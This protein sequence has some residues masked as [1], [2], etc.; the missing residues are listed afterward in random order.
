[1]ISKYNEISSKYNSESRKSG[2]GVKHSNTFLQK[3]VTES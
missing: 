1:M 3:A 2:L